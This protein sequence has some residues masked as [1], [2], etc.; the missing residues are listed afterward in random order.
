MYSFSERSTI[1][2]WG[3]EAKASVNILKKEMMACIIYF[4][5]FYWTK[6]RGMLICNKVSGP[7]LVTYL[8]CTM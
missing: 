5:V 2:I 8:D 4:R 3:F 7:D 6:V 1:L